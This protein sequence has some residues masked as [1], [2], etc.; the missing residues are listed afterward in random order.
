M[1]RKFSKEY[2]ERVNSKK[3]DLFNHLDIIIRDNI[4]DGCLFYF[5]TVNLK[6]NI[7][8]ELCQYVWITN[9]MLHSI[10]KIELLNYNFGCLEYNKKNKIHLHSIIAVRSLIGF[11]ETLLHNINKEFRNN[12]EI[13]FVIK[14]LNKFNDIKRAQSY[15]LKNIN[16]KQ[17]NYHLYICQ[18]KEY[19]FENLIEFL[20]NDYPAINLE[21]FSK[22]WQDIKGSKIINFQ[23]S[24]EIVFNFWNYYLILNNYYINK[25]GIYKKITNTLIS[26]EYIYDKNFL[27]NNFDDIFL[28]FLSEF[29]MHFEKYNLYDIKLNYLTTDKN[30]FDNFDKIITNKVNFTFKVFEFKDGL[31][32]LEYNKF[33]KREQIKENINYATLKYYNKKFVH[34][35]E[36]NEWIA[37]V[38]VTVKNEEVF[39]DLCCYL[40]NCVLKIDNLFDK[41]KTL[42][43]IGESNTGKTTFIVKPLLNFYGEENVGFLSSN[44]NFKFQDLLNKELGVFDEFKYKSSLKDQFLKL[45]SGESFLFDI[46]F[47]N[48]EKLKNLP[49]ILITNEIFK[50][51]NLETQKAFNNRIYEVIFFIKVKNINESEIQK[52]LKNEEIEIIIYWNKKLHNKI[53][54]KEITKLLEE[55]TKPTTKKLE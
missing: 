5:V 44:L 51:K 39:N 6:E 7:T 27:L 43:I 45:F 54:K 3:K 41:K 46:K 33:I 55:I 42:A 29:P 13:D 19:I 53:K 25:N 10:E 9:Y 23:N 8:T 26:Y 24:F 22:K 36:P 47:K 35:R 1:A 40:G 49:I 21:I 32:F 2:I 18:G 38:K 15:I 14:P 16:I 50:E 31:Y 52:K 48:E 12:F 28:F 30:K 20:A 4:D 37:N 11:N 34:L 17:K